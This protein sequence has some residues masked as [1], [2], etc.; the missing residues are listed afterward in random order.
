MVE[1]SLSNKFEEDSISKNLYVNFDGGQFANENIYQESLK[2][3][4]SI[5]SENQLHFGSCE[6]S[7]ISFTIRNDGSESL[8]GK[9]IVV[10]MELDG[11]SK[12][13]F[14]IGTYKVDSDIASKDKR[15]REIIAYDTIYEML[16][17]DVISWFKGLSFPI[18][19]YNF[20]NSFFEFFGVEQEEKTL[21]NDN[22]LIY[23]SQE[24][25][26][27]LSGKS[28][29]NAIC[30]INGVFGHISRENKFVYIS[31]GSS[32]QGLY[33][34]DYTFP[35]I[36]L[37]PGK[38]GGNSEVSRSIYKTLNYEE[39]SVRSIDSLQII[40]ETGSLGASS[41]SASYNARSTT[42]PNIYKVQN[43]ILTYGQ[44]ADELQSMADNMLSEVQN[45]TYI[46]AEANL[47]GNPCHEV[48]DIVAYIADDG[49]Y[50]ET[51]I[52]QRELS[53]IQAL[54]DTFVSVGEETYDT[55]IN[56]TDKNIE[57]LKSKTSDLSRR[58]STI[59]KEGS[60]L[61]VY[62]VA[63][64]PANPVTDALYLIQGE[65]VVE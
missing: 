52:L 16:N 6:S 14:I 15:K 4:E 31:L 12:N 57:T 45:V 5:N 63:T 65:V 29:L 32:Y 35:G 64:L 51:Y 61:K 7:K 40:T 42:T 20:R 17:A 33:P 27:E 47:K 13:P 56:K 50:V 36:T 60:K 59:E 23:N 46:P 44:S 54:K 30:E 21:V 34:S 53:G 39:Y 58:L 18:S 26:E 8:K 43:T 37:F 62:S 55:E 19:M 9:E 1:Y 49:T 10:S 11:D 22:M 28:V 25:E 48:G 2:L 38:K 24:E 3:E 41:G